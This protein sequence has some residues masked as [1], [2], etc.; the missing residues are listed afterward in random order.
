MDAETLRWIA[1]AALGLICALIGVIYWLLRRDIDRI[2]K[3]LHA[4]RGE[5]SPVVL[6]VAVIREKLGMGPRE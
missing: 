6:W 1:G 5:V 2:A 3:N 4:L